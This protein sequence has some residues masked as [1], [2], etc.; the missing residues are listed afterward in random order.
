MS[1]TACLQPSSSQP[2]YRYTSQ[3]V[4]DVVQKT[5]QVENFYAQ[6]AIAE[7]E[8]HAVVYISSMRVFDVDYIHKLTQEVKEASTKSQ[9]IFLNDDLF[10]PK[11]YRDARDAHEGLNKSLTILNI[12]SEAKYDLSR[13]PLEIHNLVKA[14]REL[15]IVLKRCH[16]H[17][18][19]RFDALDKPNPVVKPS[20]YL[21]RVTGKQRW[22][23][24]PN[25]YEYQI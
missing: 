20:K 4:Q 3:K 24:R 8:T 11:T 2:M 16:K 1:G 17:L 13:T 9:L 5:K 15:F 10:T 19:A 22:D 6:T 18:S 21:R 23:L 14:I 25:T 7:Q 12:L